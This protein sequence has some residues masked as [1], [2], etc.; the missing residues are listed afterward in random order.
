MQEWQILKHVWLSEHWITE[1]PRTNLIRIIDTQL[2]D[3]PNTLINRISSV[4]INSD[5]LHSIAWLS[6]HPD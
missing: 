4:Q 6:E 2:F 1:F 3:Y 5:N